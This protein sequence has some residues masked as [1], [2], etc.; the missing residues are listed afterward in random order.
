MPL[1]GDGEKGVKKNFQ[2]EEPGG[3]E[4]HW[5]REPGMER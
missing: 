1:H 2:S 3:E 4:E 5:G